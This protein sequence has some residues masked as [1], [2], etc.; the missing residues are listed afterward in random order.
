MSAGRTE[1]E[2]NNFSPHYKRQYCVAFFSQLQD[3]VEQQQTVHPQLLKQKVLFNNQ[4]KCNYAPFI[5]YILDSC[6]FFSFVERVQGMPIYPVCVCRSIHRPL[7]WCI[8]T[9]SSTLMTVR[10]GRRGLWRCGQTTVWSFMTA[11]RCI[12]LQHTNAASLWIIRS[13]SNFIF[14][15]LTIKLR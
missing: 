11:R 13:P 12:T 1:A 10:S 6:V 9:A 7:I 4:P 3:E 14:V 15:M 8:R 5:G 2:L